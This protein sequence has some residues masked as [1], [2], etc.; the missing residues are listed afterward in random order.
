VLLGDVESIDPVARVVKL[1]DGELKFDY[2]I[3]CTGVS[4]SYFGH[5]E[6]ST[7]APGL[8]TIED[9][10]EIRRR[11]LLAFEQAERESDAEARATALTFVVVGGGPTGVE[12]AGAMIEIARKAIPRDFR[13]V[14]T[15]S[16]RVILIEGQDRVLAGFPPES[17][18]R[19]KRDLEELGVQV[20][21]GTRV[22][23][24]D[25]QG[26]EVTPAGGGEARRINA[27]SVI[28]AAGVRGSPIAGSLGVALDKAGRVPVGPDLS[29]PGH[30]NIFVAGDLASITMPA[31]ERPVPGVAPAAMQMGRHAGRVIRE[32]LLAQ[33]R[34]LDADPAHRAHFVYVNKGEL[35]TIGRARAVGVLGFGLKL[36]LAG[37]VA[38]AL[39]ACV[40]V[41]YLIGFRNRL[42]T[43]L[44][45]VWSYLFFERGARLIT[46]DSRLHLREKQPV[47]PEV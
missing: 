33:S 18:Q 10:L 25:E 37:F 1:A 19:A 13:S 14:N 38:W 6:W 47:T 12:L 36:K 5:D 28:W 35:A 40:H 24:I 46:G 23:N 45:W 31:S 4:H 44:D 34:G 22:T 21:L 2:L 27:A 8:K 15:A 39:W 41:A 9:A 32:E 3:V 11:F 30:A 43:M 7:L 20:L 42:F 26:V 17:S 16:A 29:I